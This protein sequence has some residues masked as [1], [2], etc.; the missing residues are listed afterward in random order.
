[1]DSRLGTPAGWT[2]WLAWLDCLAG[3]TGWP[4]WLA[5]WRARLAG[6]AGW[7]DWL[8]GLAGGAGWR[9]PLDP[10][11]RPS[12]KQAQNGVKEAKGTKRA[13][14][15]RTGNY[16]A[17]SHFGNGHAGR[18]SAF[19]QFGLFWTLLRVNTLLLVLLTG[20]VLLH[21]SSPRFLAECSLLPLLPLLRV[22]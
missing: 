8:S 1:M 18:P 9:D 2:G 7:P 14:R 21:C 11:I 6:G 16:E 10:R 3:W 13:K 12:F 5:G 15:T 19:A 4:D 20:P 17:K 22:I